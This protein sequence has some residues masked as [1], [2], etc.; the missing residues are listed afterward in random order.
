MHR[1][2]NMS[3]PLLREIEPPAADVA[4]LASNARRTPKK[5]SEIIDRNSNDL[6]KVLAAHHLQTYPPKAQKA[7]RSLQP[8]E[9]ASWLGIAEGYLRQLAIESTIGTAN[10]NGRRTFTIEDIDAIRARLASQP[11]A[12][13]N[14]SPRRSSDEKV[15]VICVMNFKGGSGKTTT[16]AHL[17]EFFA[18]SGYRTLAID[19]DPQASLSSLFGLQPAKDVGAGDTILGVIQYN[20]VQRPMS[21]VVRSTYIPHLQI[22]PGNIELLEFEH[23]TASALANRTKGDTLFFDRVG[24]ALGQ[25]EQLYD[26]VVIDCPPSM[27]FLTVSALTAATS[28]L[29]TVHPQMLDVM[30]MNQFLAMIANLLKV[31]A[32]AGAADEIAWVNYLI[33]RFEPGDGPQNQMAALLRSI[34]GDQVL[35]HTVLKSTAISDAGLTNQTLYEVERSQFTRTTYDRALESVDAVNREIE[36]LVHHTWSRVP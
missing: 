28:L 22:V 26:I 9:A 5:T 2:L 34:L 16:A 20:D 4:A 17:S 10:A 6:S 29:I 8:G 3:K 1:D 11:G 35:N 18:L 12:R 30:S 24:R 19:L 14:Y 21:E 13:R 23:E 36:A 31:V 27:G 32:K 25:V 7:F 15:Q 33:T